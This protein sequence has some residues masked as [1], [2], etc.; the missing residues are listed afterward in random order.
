M[1]YPLL[2][3][4]GV[5]SSAPTRRKATQSAM[6]R[7]GRRDHLTATSPPLEPCMR[8]FDAHGASMPS[9]QA[10]LRRLPFGPVHSRFLLVAAHVQE[11]VVCLV[12]L[13][14]FMPW[15]CMVPLQFF[16]VVQHV[17]A[18]RADMFLVLG[19]VPVTGVEGHGLSL[20]PVRPVFLQTRVVRRRPA[21]YL[22]MPLDGGPYVAWEV[23][24]CAPASRTAK[25]R[26]LL[27]M[28]PCMASPSSAVYRCVCAS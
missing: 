15:P 17:T 13:S 11:L 18:D 9:A 14:A 26:D 21:L 3:A 22:H 12:I 2:P 23:G 7:S 16:A 8:P 24:P 20:V 28:V 27:Q 10:F 5:A 4:D 19:N 1:G 6:A 25:L